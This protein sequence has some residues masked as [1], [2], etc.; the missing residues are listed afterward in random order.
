MIE[1]LKK[2]VVYTFLLWILGLL[3]LT[4]VYCIN[5]NSIF[6]NIQK[7][8]ALYEYEG[9]Y[10]QWAKG[11]NFTKL[12]NWTDTIMLSMASFSSKH[13]LEDALL[14]KYY[15]KTSTNP[16]KS[17]I[18]MT[19]NKEFK[20]SFNLVEYSRYWHGYLIF[21]KPMLSLF[22][23]SEIRIMNFFIQFLLFVCVLLKLSQLINKEFAFI[24]AFS[25]YLL[26]P[27]S[28]GMSFQFS[29]IY[30]ISLVSI[31][32]LLH[33]LH[34]EN[35]SLIKHFF[36]LG[37][38]VSYFD[39]LT[40]PMFSLCSSLALCVL[41]VG[42]EKKSIKNINLMMVCS[43]CSWCVGYATMWIGKWIFVSIFTSRSIFYE[44]YKSILFR[45]NGSISWV[46]KGEVSFG[47]VIIAQFSNID[48][49]SLIIALVFASIMIAYALYNKRF[50]MREN[51]H[52]ILPLMLISFIP[53]IWYCLLKNHSYIHAWFT[54]RG[55][56]SSLFCFMSIV[57]LFVAPIKRR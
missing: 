2:Y 7:S 24:F 23:V 32:I 53:I 10:P 19:K 21:L 14:S 9:V 48:K 49:N 56:A 15:R 16:T 51:K 4:A 38:S 43:I 3:S 35:S 11:K 52:I 26:N 22:T 27:I 5:E 12:D 47:D 39:F 1:Y 28:I 8:I 44:I 40:Y 33:R 13:P 45:I 18:E 6:N 17:L 55:L 37:A 42:S 20:K 34:N 46:E 50:Y 29:T 36:V 54:Y 57:F 31:F 25:I 41:L 30:Y